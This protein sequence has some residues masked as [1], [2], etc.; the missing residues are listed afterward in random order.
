MDSHGVETLAD[1]KDWSH[2]LSDECASRRNSVMQAMHHILA[3][4]GIRSLGPGAPRPEYF[5][6]YQFHLVV[7]SPDGSTQT[8]QITTEKYDTNQGGGALDI[9]VALQYGQGTGSAP[10]VDFMSEH[11]RLTH[12]P[13]YRNWSCILTSGNTSA[14]DIAL[15]MFGRP[16]DYILVDEY[17]YPVVYETGLPLG[18]RFVS[19][20]MDSEG[21]VP[22]SL[23]TTLSH[24]NTEVK[25]SK[26][27]LLYV[28]PAGQN[29][30]G[31]TT[32]LE[33]KNAIYRIA[34]RHNLY[35]LE[36]DP[37]YFIQMPLYPNARSM[38]VKGCPAERDFPSS[39]ADCIGKLIPSY[40]SIDTD[41]RVFRM[42][43][44]SKIIAPGVRM[45]WVTAS[46]QI[47]ERMIRAHELSVQNPSGLSQ[48]MLFKLLHDNWGHL[49]FARWL[50]HLQHEYGMRR[51][52]LLNA[53]EQHVPRDI[54]SWQPPRAG[55]FVCASPFYSGWTNI[56][57]GLQ[58]WV[59][60]D[61]KC[62]PEATQ[63]SP[64][65]IEQDIYEAAIECGTLVVPGSWFLAPESR[66]TM[67][68]IYFRMT[69][70]A[71]PIESFDEAIR[72]FGFAVRRVVSLAH[73]A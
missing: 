48:L 12:R 49:G 1:A 2:M 7:S 22:D 46:E 47:I 18:Y 27:K 72:C 34:Q 5:P 23:E 65:M 36:D 6:F 66:N 64:R 60:V 28:I 44:F 26:P 71:A 14:L 55:F 67:Q 10:L 25:G 58:V 13:P 38:D 29:P 42:D 33:R 21:M 9:A 20:K 57:G 32:S 31:A 43:S 73:P 19:I 45:G 39:V 52:A 41:G 50:H 15:R 56:N 69:F 37:Y 30:T 8:S 59:S 35:L 62:H 61:W 17:T 53:L 70:A 54:V 3:Q 24:W 68:E 16:G 11:I 51:D 4:P 40:L 63:R